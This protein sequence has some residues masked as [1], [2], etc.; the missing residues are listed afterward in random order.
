MRVHRIVG[1]TIGLLLMAGGPAAAIAQEATPASGDSL[2]SGYGLP[3]VVIEATDEGVTDPGELAAGLTLITFD[4]QSGA[5]ATLELYPT[6]DQA[7]YDAL[8]EAL[9]TADPEAMAPPPAFYEITISGGISAPAGASAGVILDLVPGTWAFNYF[10]PDEAGPGINIPTQVEVTGEPN[11]L[12]PPEADVVAEMYEMEFTIPD[13]VA[14]GPQVWEVTTTG[15]QPHFVL[16]SRYPEAFTEEQV[17][18]L[19]GA[20]DPTGTPDP[21]ASALQFDLFEDAFESPVLS[22]GQTNWYEIDL[23]PGYYVALCFIP[24]PE[25]GAPHALLGMHELFE[26]V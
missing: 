15:M 22:S 25:T 11:G 5:D 4:N 20:F 16:M 13:E 26:V 2:L 6:A 18:E 24:D 19:L 3:E 10:V 7:S 12:A 23:E 1:L 8:I 14:T 21:S 9:A 17:M